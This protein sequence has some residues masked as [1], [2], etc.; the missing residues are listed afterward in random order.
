MLTLYFS[1]NYII[2]WLC[3]PTYWTSAQIWN[4]FNKKKWQQKPVWQNC[5]SNAREPLSTTKTTI[6]A[7]MLYELLYP[8]SFR[9]LSALSCDT[10][11]IALTGFPSNTM[12]QCY[13]DDDAVADH[14]LFDNTECHTHT[15]SKYVS[16]FVAILNRQFNASIFYYTNN[17]AKL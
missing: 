17:A 4:L 7:Y 3:L 14:K 15:H 9:A 5:S 8:S 12:M 13:Y 11:Q 10:N 2:I 16:H 1:W 6:C